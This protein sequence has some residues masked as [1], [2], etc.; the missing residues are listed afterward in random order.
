MEEAT[1]FMDPERGGHRHTERD[2]QIDIDREQD[3]PSKDTSWDT[4][5]L[6][7]GHQVSCLCSHSALI[8]SWLNLMLSYCNHFSKTPP[9]RGQDFDKWDFGADVCG[10]H[11]LFP[12]HLFF[13]IAPILSS[14]IMKG[15]GVREMVQWA[16]CLIHKHEELSLDSPEPIEKGSYGA[17]C[18]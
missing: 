16:N 13:P 18:L 2:R 11:Y 4:Y 12:S 17:M 3:L 7:W 14:L 1:Y 15:V 10:S 5:F 8:S 6:W 9:S